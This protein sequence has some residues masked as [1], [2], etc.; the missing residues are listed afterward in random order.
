MTR[1]KHTIVLTGIGI[2]AAGFAIAQGPRP[3]PM[4]NKENPGP[5]PTARAIGPNVINF[6]AN[7]GSFKVLP[8]NDEA[9][10]R[11]TL[12]FSFNGS[13]LVSGLKGSLTT[14]GTV[15]E[16]Y[17]NDKYEKRL[18]FGKGSMTLTGSVRSVQFFGRDVKGTLRG[19]GLI[20]FYGEFDKNLDTGYWEYPGGDRGVWG[21]GG[22]QKSVP[23][24]VYGAAGNDIKIEKSK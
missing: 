14:T 12:S 13:V 10:T 3:M 17:K 24:I 23:Q 6:G 18:F 5:P 20:T 16:E 15:R 2:I 11:G 7:V 9:P 1:K 8:F 4:P 21:T 22:M 19:N